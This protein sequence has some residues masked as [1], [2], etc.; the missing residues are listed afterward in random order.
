L[1]STYQQGWVFSDD[2]GQLEWTLG[3]SDFTSVIADP[4]G[5]PVIADLKWHNVVATF[6]RTIGVAN[7]YIDGVQVDTRSIQGLGSLDNG[8]PIALAQDPSGKYDP[9]N[10]PNFLGQY[11]LDDVGI[12]RRVL[13]TYDA[14]SIYHVGLAGK[15]FDVPSAPPPTLSIG[16]QGGVW[17]I[18]YTGTLQSSATVNGTYGNVPGASSPY[19]VPTGSAA[20]QFYRASN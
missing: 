1:G 13:S 9:S 10:N 3:A 5:G 12:W 6:D 17:V 15:S 4:V 19:T 2:A 18:T 8:N 16:R 11:Q 20:M 7:T 14:Q